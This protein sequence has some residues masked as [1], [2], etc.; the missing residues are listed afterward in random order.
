MLA[1][2][3]S[4]FPPFYIA[5]MALYT[6]VTTGLARTWWNHTSFVMSLRINMWKWTTEI[7]SHDHDC[8]MQCVH[9]G[10][11]TIAAQQRIIKL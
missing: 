10:H 4:S 3:N 2:F 8:F 7:L 6:R 5:V 11:V 9:C 1:I